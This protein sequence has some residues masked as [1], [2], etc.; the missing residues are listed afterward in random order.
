[1]QCVVPTLSQQI[2]WKGQGRQVVGVE[3]HQLAM[4]PIGRGDYGAAVL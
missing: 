3:V 1:M 2:R 4:Q